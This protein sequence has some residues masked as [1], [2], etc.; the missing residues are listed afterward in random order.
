MNQIL[1]FTIGFLVPSVIFI[2]LYFTLLKKK[3]CS[4]DLKHCPASGVDI[5]VRS[6]TSDKTWQGMCTKLGTGMILKS[7]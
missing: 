3:M 2:I 1:I 5:C 4:G 6:D 7:K